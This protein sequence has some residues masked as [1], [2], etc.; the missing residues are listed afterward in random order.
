MNEEVQPEGQPLGSVEE[1]ELLELPGGR[2]AEAQ[3][4]EEVERHSRKGVVQGVVHERLL[5]P[6]ERRADHLLEPP[7]LR[8][9]LA[10]VWVAVVEREALVRVDDAQVVEVRPGSQDLRAAVGTQ[11]PTRQE[12]TQG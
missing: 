4:V 9:L 12:G 7:Q 6:G 2:V 8:H 10:Q 11:A 3:V 1:E 5:E